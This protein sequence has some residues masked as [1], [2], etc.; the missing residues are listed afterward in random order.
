MRIL[1]DTLIYAYISCIVSMTNLTNCWADMIL[2]LFDFVENLELCCTINEEVSD[3]FGNF[4][5]PG[6]G[7]M[8]FSVFARATLTHSLN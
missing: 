4:I 1:S 8:C 2:S 7:I 5:E 3:D 6:N